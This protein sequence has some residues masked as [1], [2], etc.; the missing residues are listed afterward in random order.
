[1]FIKQQGSGPRAFWNYA[2]ATVTVE[3]LGTSIWLRD[4]T[5]MR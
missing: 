5:I 4:R 1:M 3:T 2:S